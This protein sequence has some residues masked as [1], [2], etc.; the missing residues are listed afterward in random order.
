MHSSASMRR[1][2]V[3]GF[4]V[5]I[6]FSG[7]WTEPVGAQEGSGAIVPE[8]AQLELLFDGGFF[9]EGPAVAPDGTVYFSDITNTANSGMQAGYIWRHD[10]SSGKTTVFRS[11]SGMSNGI[12]F[13]LEDRMVVA[14][15]ADFG[16]RCVTR[17]DMTTGKSEIIAGLY[18]GRSF[19]SPNDLAI[20]EQGRVYFTDPR[21]VGHEA[22]EQPVLGVYRIDPDGSVSLIITD[23]GT[24]NGILVSPDQRT[25]Y[26]ASIGMQEY[27]LHA[28][29]AYD[30]AAD[31]S[32]SS[33]RVVADFAPEYG[34]D[35][36]AIDVDGNLYLARPA[37]A[38]HTPGIYVY[39]P[40][41]E[42]LA[43]IPTPG[44]PTNATFGR[45]PTG[46]TLYITA[47]TSLYKI[48]LNREGHQPAR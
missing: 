28:L 18:N 43:L 7:G 34:P 37:V 22:I 5:A 31:G 1:S 4:V 15:G 10:P 21:Y 12:I 6:A 9:L 48:E 44:S 46:K 39:S 45:G 35:G 20:D 25:L 2:A 42:E 29:L 41:G 23:A 24:P 17:T 19:N 8:N 11:P 26:V 33:R 38:P 27:S 36:M 32:V 47:G 3:L 13:D 40:D 16:G 30:L 14:Q